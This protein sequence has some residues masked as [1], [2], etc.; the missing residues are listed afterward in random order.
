MLKSDHDSVFYFLLSL[1]ILRG[2]LLYG[3][4]ANWSEALLVKRWVWVRALTRSYCVGTVNKS[5]AQ[6]SSELL[7]SVDVLW[8]VLNFG[9]WTSSNTVVSYCFIFSNIFLL[10]CMTGCLTMPPI[11]CCLIW[12]L[13]VIDLCCYVTDKS[14][15]FLVDV[16]V[17]WDDGQQNGLSAGIYRIQQ[18]EVIRRRSSGSILPS[19]AAAAASA[20]G[21]HC[22]AAG[23]PNLYLSAAPRVNDRC[24]RTVVLCLLVFW[25]AVRRNSLYT[26]Q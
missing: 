25:V 2:N 10:Y 23:G 15:Y 22:P 21:G 7:I 5:F 3:T 20:T 11:F 17:G 16:S 4:A 19:S 9:R 26:G 1:L 24:Y 13:D 14:T 8:S 18:P 6:S 12:S